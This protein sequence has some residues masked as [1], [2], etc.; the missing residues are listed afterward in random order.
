LGLLQLGTLRDKV[1]TSQ[2]ALTGEHW[3]MHTKTP[4]IHS[5]V[6]TKMTTYITSRKDRVWMK[7]RYDDMIANFVKAIANAYRIWEMYRY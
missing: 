5:A 2:A 7:R 1:L 4:Q 6:L 3:K